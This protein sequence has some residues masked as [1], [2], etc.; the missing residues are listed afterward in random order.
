MPLA[1]A[2]LEKLAGQAFNQQRWK[3][4][5]DLFGQL[6][7]QQSSASHL[8]S[9][10]VCHHRLDQLDTALKYFE[11]S[12]A[13]DSASME[14]WL[15]CISLANTLGK[16]A[17]ALQFCLQAENHGLNHPRIGTSKAIVLESLGRI[18]EAL[19]TYD[20][21]LRIDP[22]WADALLNRG[23]LLLQSQRAAEACANNRLLVA[24]HPQLAA[25]HFNLGEACLASGAFVE[26][27]DAYRRARILEPGNQRA[28]LQEAYALCR[29]EQYAA[30]QSLLNQAWQAFPQLLREDFRRIFPHSPALERAP[31]ARTIFLAAEFERLES[32]DWQ[33]HAA[34]RRRFAELLADTDLPGD[35]PLAF[36]AFATAMPPDLQLSL[37]R[38]VASNFSAVPLTSRLTAVE[39]RSRPLR[40]GYLSQDF[41][42]H[43]TALLIHRIFRLH[44]RQRFHVSAFAIGP[45]NDDPLRQDIAATADQFIDLSPL[46]DNAAARR[47]AA[48]KIDILID[49]TGYMDHARPGILSRRPAPLQIAW[50]AYL[51]SS[52]APWMDYIVLDPVVAPPGS[53]L[54]ECCSEA[55]I[56]MPRTMYF[57][58][59][60][61]QRPIAPPG[62][63]CGLPTDRPVLA[64]FHNAFKIDPEIFAL[65]MR[66]LKH[67]P[68][69]V[70]WLQAGTPALMHNLRSAA[71]SHGIATERLL[72][73]PKIAHDLHLQRLACADLFLD[74]PQCNG[75][76]TLC[77]ALV[78]G[79]PVIT[80]AG[81]GIA[82][83]IGASILSGAGLPEGVTDS[84]QQYEQ[85]AHSWLQQPATLLQM[86]DRLAAAKSHAPLFQS[87][88]WTR[89]FEQALTTVWQNYRNG[90]APKDVTFSSCPES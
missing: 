24:A 5:A 90:L 45:V 54:S 34:F 67:Q 16:H 47:I 15:G 7:T 19:R 80:C 65:W 77:D 73:A 30:A 52:G 40:I 53:R 6:V 59:F 12:V 38:K 17:Q 37:A 1:I 28:L 26:A 32:C 2:E 23:A 83:R 64:A 42:N 74:T 13:L 35:F 22:Q 88:H 75:G 44:D 72:F 43:A 58:S 82:Q 86:R 21:V 56:R 57:C 8:F 18:D 68:A 87:A 41:R 11:E 10:A 81:D 71:A 33:H 20:Q 31:D 62:T 25:G 4:A 76:T 78:A 69:A 66:L 9:L 51:A 39:D 79:V 63:D 85:L 36:R 48:E 50:I 61:D 89:D 14:A 70:L 84:L 46:D 55:I 60:A 27:A 29:L 49:L 3:R